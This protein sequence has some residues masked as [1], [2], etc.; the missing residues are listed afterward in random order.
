MESFLIYLAIVIILLLIVKIYLLTQNKK[1]KKTI[2]KINKAKQE[3]L[4]EPV[5]L[6][7][8]I[9]PN[10]CIG[11]AACI[12]ACPEKDILG[13][14]NNKAVT[15]NA[16]RCVGHGACSLA[17]PMDAISLVIGTEKRGVEIPFIS[18]EFETNIPML[19]IAGELGGMGLIKNAVEQGKQAI[20]NIYKKLNKNHSAEFDVGIVGSGPAGISAS[21]N[22][23]KLGLRFITFEQYSIGGTVYNFPRNKIV[24]TSPMT[25][26]LYGKVNATEI[27]KDKLI[28]LWLEI[29]KK[30][31]I[32]ILENTKVS[33]IIRENDIFIIKT[34]S[35]IYSA[36]AVLLAIGRRG[37]PRKLGVPG[38]EKSK[39][40]YRLLDPN[41][42]SNKNILIVGGGD[43]A[44]EAAIS[45]FN[46]ENKITLSY[47]G[48]EFSR[49]KEKNFNT[50]NELIRNNKIVFL[51]ETN[52]KAIHDDY[53]ELINKNSEIIEIKN[54][55]VYI[56][57]G[58]ELPNDFLKKIGISITK[59]FGEKV[60]S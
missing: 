35:K 7:P 29:L 5:S 26:P 51:A 57:I 43:S 25:L 11:T 41:A 53:V 55:F 46:S 4:F 13:L 20:D 38:E 23:K 16:A 49:V 14:L 36:A 30:Y 52:V 59:K 15:I 27:S 17:C 21:L 6:H 1:S 39:V 42:I 12:S 40:Y 54:D 31:D 47:R 2:I 33:D 45:L 37:T 18:P 22:S 60:V 44:I 34:D 8:V 58:G 10:R 48:K 19:F 28:S 56:F 32:K 9:D 50:I 3:G 24:M